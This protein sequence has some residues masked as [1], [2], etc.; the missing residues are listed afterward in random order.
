MRV[1]QR[2]LESSTGA[3]GSV[4]SSTLKFTGARS[5]AR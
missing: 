5:W 4:T 2:G 3:R 1:R